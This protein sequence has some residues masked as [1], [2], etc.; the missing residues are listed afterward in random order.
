MSDADEATLTVEDLAAYY[1]TGKDWIETA[2]RKRQIPFLMV[3]RKI[4]FTPEQRDRITASRSYEP[5]AVPTRDEIAERRAA[6]V[7]AT[8][9]KTA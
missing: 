6:A 5:K 2:V 3:A 4:R 8:T 9:R 1:K 7:R